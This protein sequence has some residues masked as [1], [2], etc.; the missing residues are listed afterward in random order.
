V[1]ATSEGPDAL[2]LAT[3]DQFQRRIDMIKTLFN[4]DQLA[5]KSSKIHFCK[6]C[7]SDT[8][9]TTCLLAPIREKKWLN[10]GFH[11]KSD[12]DKFDRV[13]HVN[14]SVCEAELTENS[15][16]Q[17]SRL[18]ECRRP[19]PVTEDQL[20]R[21]TD[22][23]K[24]LFNVDQLASRS[25]KIK[26]CK[27]SYSDTEFTTSFSAPI[28]KQKWLNFHFHFKTDSDQ[29]DRVSHSATESSPPARVYQIYK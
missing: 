23:I 11:F 2:L 25:S 24:T 3:R 4:L 12:F 18:S 26:F 5:S 19:V 13:S 27:I 6:T 20:Q 8:E 9:F 7:Y 14:E 22:M 29:F 28:R 10:F 1:W 17:R 15:Q 21:M 16:G